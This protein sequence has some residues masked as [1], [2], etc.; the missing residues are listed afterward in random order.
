LTSIA[1]RLAPTGKNPPPCIQPHIKHGQTLL[2]DS[3]HKSTLTHILTYHVV[4]GK[5]DM[6]T[7]AE[8]IR[9]GGGKAE[10]TGAGSGLDYLQVEPLALAAIE[11]DRSL[12]LWAIPA[13]GKPISLG[14][15]PAGSKDKVELSDT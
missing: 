14:V 6:K 2:A 15:I 9:A 10:L 4:A 7:L 5:L 8:K 13:D 1:S 11:P 3:H 12:E